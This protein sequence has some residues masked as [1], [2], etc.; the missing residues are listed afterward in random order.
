MQ[1]EITI[2]IVNFNT[3]QFIKLALHAYWHLSAMTY[4]VHICDNGSTDEDIQL[5]KDCTCRYP[6]VTVSY[7]KQS[8]PGSIGHS[9]ALN[10]LIKSVTTPYFIIQDA[11]CIPLLFH[12]DSLLNEKLLEGY[13]AAGVAL[14]VDA[15]GNTRP[16]DF[17]KVFLTMFKTEQFKSMS[18]DM[19]PGDIINNQDT[20]WQIRERYLSN[21]LNG[22]VFP[23]RST[24]FNKTG[25][26]GR[27][28]CA[29]YYTDV[30]YN[31]LLCAHFGR[32]SH[33]ISG[34]YSP[35]WRNFIIAKRRFRNVKRE[36]I[37]ISEKIIFREMIENRVQ[38]AK[39]RHVVV[40]PACG[41][42][43]AQYVLYD[44][45]RIV[46]T[47]GDWH[48]AQ[49]ENCGFIYTQ[50]QPDLAEKYAY[51]PASYPCYVDATG[52]STQNGKG[53]RW[54]IYL[55]L[56]KNWLGYN[57]DCM[58][59]ILKMITLPMRQYCL[60][61]V[62]P[63]SR[64]ERKQARVL[65]IGC[66]NGSMLDIFR[67]LGWNVTGI[68]FSEKGG[69]AARS[70][71]L[72][73][74]TIAVENADFPNESFDAIVMAMVLEHLDHPKEVIEKITRWLRPGGE[75]VLSVPDIGALEYR[76]FGQYHRALHLPQHQNH[77]TVVSLNA[78]L[79]QYV[80]KVYHQFSTRDLMGDSLLVSNIIP[81]D[82]RGS[83]VGFSA[84]VKAFWY[85]A[86]FFGFSSGMTIRAVKKQV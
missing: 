69:N 76:I 34:K 37:K 43:N 31:L 28:I 45:D 24:V 29:E 50:P 5:L 17:P 57:D 79:K 68:E 4:E 40:C 63:R 13:G 41:S 9:E 1:P 66:G 54:E 64:A 25:P 80:V 16:L 38:M 56:L 23:A 74:Q 27:F 78:L 77:F 84:P 49:C 65:E 70:K 21:G 12:W 35:G 33:F 85:I 82:L 42:G 60:S 32:G 51:Y 81:G 2:L 71:G 36:W 30:K 3:A 18:I 11:D 53:L 75:L 7:R 52:V 19:A 47:V 62:I 26:F 15:R 61:Q 86:A 46:N 58:S 39:G 8:T 83:I 20:G 67:K 48:L 73:V 55:S 22:Y 14:P 10:E 44:Y 72:N 59:T 6:N